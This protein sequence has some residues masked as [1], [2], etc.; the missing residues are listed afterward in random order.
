MPISKYRKPSHK[1]PTAQFILEAILPPLILVSSSLI[2]WSD[3]FS[4][5]NLFPGVAL[6]ILWVIVAVL[7]WR[8][9][10]RG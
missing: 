3:L 5:A 10:T 6:I 7:I 8:V 9:K 2:I 1:F 4:K